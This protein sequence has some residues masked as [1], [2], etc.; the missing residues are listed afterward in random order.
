MRLLRFCG[1]TEGI[2]YLTVFAPYFAEASLW[3]AQVVRGLDGRIVVDLTFIP[4][5]VVACPASVIQ[6]AL[7]FVPVAEPEHAP[8]LEMLFYNV[9]AGYVIRR[10]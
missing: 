4:G 2:A 5:V 1:P 9:Y 6:Y 7:Y 8:V 3:L 10:G